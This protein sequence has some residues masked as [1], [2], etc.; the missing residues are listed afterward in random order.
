MN[1]VMHCNNKTVDWLSGLLVITYKPVAKFV[2]QYP[3]V[4][5]QHKKIKQKYKT[6]KKLKEKVHKTI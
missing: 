2:V 1:Y 6:E 3:A 4:H 5:R